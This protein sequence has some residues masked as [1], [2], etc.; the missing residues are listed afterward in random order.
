MAGVFPH[1]LVCPVRHLRAALDIVG[2]EEF[3][4]FVPQGF[5]QEDLIDLL[6]GVSEF[7]WLWEWARLHRRYSRRGS[8]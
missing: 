6:Y 2:V 5:L 3:V 8:T 4:R 1:L 7:R